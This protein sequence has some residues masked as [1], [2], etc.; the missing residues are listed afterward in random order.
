M[1]G[2]RE[3]ELGFWWALTESLGDDAIKQRMGELMRPV[4]DGLDL[5]RVLLE[6]GGSL[7]QVLRAVVSGAKT[8]PLGMGKLTLDCVPVPTLFI[9]QS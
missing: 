2:A 4:V 6:P 3:R 8:I 5:P 9:Q 7:R 1:T